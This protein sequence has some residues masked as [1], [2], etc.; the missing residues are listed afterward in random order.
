MQ[1][2][3][4][5]IA[6]SAA[7]V[8]LVAAGGFAVSASSAG[9][10]PD[11]AT[12]E[13]ASIE[14]AIAARINQVRRGRGLRALRVNRRLAAAA[15]F[16]SK[17]MGRRGYFAHTSADGTP[18]WRRVKRFYESRGF[19]DWSVGENLIWGTDRYGA[20]FAVRQWMASAPHRKNILARAWREIGVGAVFF[21]H[22]PGEYGGRA[23]TIVTADFGTRS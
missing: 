20:A 8:V 12:A 19:R 15:D 22:A 11:A 21:A 18:F 16:H 23:V 6:I 7:V 14:A 3:R 10:R 2:R 13:M 17:D 4:S 5:V 1:P 9:Q